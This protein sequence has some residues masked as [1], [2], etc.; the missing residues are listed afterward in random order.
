MADSMKE[1]SVA[2]KRRKKARTPEARENQ[3][4]ALVVDI[5][6]ERIRSGKA[7]SQELVYWL[8]LASSKEKLEREKLEMENELLAAKAEAIRAQQNTEEMYKKALAAMRS[9]Q[10]EPEDEDDGL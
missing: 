9:Y 1:P 10:G 6:E 8:K 3:I 4:I 2:P 5:E 7:T